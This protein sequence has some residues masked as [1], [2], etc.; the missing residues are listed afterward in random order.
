MT[1]A[2][3]VAQPALIKDISPSQPMTEVP[4]IF[5]LKHQEMTELL[6]RFFYGTEEQGPIR[7]DNAWYF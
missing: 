7:S 1:P 3:N 4:D 6:P 5:Q 2:G